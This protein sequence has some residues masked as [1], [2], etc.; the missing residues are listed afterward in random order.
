MR[1]RVWVASSWTERDNNKKE[2]FRGDS[3]GEA[4]A[5]EHS[6]EQRSKEEKFWN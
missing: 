5:E 3:V 1:D 4:G 2:I 6:S